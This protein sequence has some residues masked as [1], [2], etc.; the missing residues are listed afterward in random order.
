[1]AR[2]YANENFPLATVEAL[3]RLGHEVL[4]TMDAGQA[5][6]AVPDQAVLDFATR[7][8]RALL[9]FNRRD[10][11]R[12]H[13]ADPGHAGIIACTYDPDFNALAARIHDALRDGSS[14][15]GRLIR[16]NRSG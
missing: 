8:E 11:I 6:Q 7:D 15:R 2:L 5:G 12:L 14:T 9:T 16:I 13:N 3:R 10:F 1:M 4:T